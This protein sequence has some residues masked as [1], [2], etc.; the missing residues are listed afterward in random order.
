MKGSGNRTRAIIS[1]LLSFVV[2]LGFGC[3]GQRARYT[4]SVVEYLYPQTKDPIATPG[5]PV[6]A[7]PMRVGIAFVPGGSGGPH[8]TGMFQ[9]QPAGFSLTEK[10]RTELMQQVAEHFKGRDF[11]KAI[12]VIPSAYL[13]PR[14]GFDN[15]D[16]V[17]SLYGVESI[18]LL[19]YDQTQFTDEGLLS[20][21]YW[22]IVGAYVVPGEK[23][24][25]HTMVDAVVVHI[26][27]RKLLFRA[28]G[29][30]HIKGH[31]TP[32]N[33]SEQL[34][35]DSDRGFNDAVAQMVKNLDEQLVVFQERVKNAPQEYQVVRQG[36]SRGGGALD[37]LTAALVALLV[38]GGWWW[39]RRKG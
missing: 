24:D 11:I 36:E 39:S 10:K 2:A 33:L 26:P 35:A 38:T 3:A 15:L 13:S 20:L 7:L 6:L 8:G 37:S 21:T 1:L 29:I 17:R 14:G 9:G 23:N 28:P 31:S 12:E 4:T 25:T 5:V 22:T 18:T 27:S 30:S 32:V 16:Q 34:R 19:S